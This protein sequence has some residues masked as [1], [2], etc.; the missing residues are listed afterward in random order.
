MHTQVPSH[1]GATPAMMNEV[2][3]EDSDPEAEIMGVEGHQLAEQVC[4]GRE[5]FHTTRDIFQRPCFSHERAH[6]FDAAIPH[7]S[8]IHPSWAG[9]MHPDMLSDHVGPL[10]GDELTL[11]DPG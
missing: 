3:S 5:I 11:Q 6:I 8:R 7:R 2:D 1:A 10:V 4:R 9:R